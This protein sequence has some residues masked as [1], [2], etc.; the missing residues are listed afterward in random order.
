[1]LC[2]FPHFLIAFR[3]HKPKINLYKANSS[4]I[5]VINVIR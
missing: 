1:M 3:Q 4:N 2:Q 5:Y